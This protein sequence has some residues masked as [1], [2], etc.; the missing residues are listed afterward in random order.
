MVKINQQND[1]K[2]KS[3]VSQEVKFLQARIDGSQPLSILFINR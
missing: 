1:K 2:E 3:L